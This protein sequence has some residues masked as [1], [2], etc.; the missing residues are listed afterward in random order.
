MSFRLRALAAWPAGEPKAGPGAAA[1]GLSKY[2]APA[3]PGCYGSGARGNMSSVLFIA[4]S[5]VHDLYPGGGRLSI[6]FVPWR[7][8]YHAPS[9]AML[10]VLS[11]I[12]HRHEFLFDCIDVFHDKRL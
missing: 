11:Q 8:K 12:H 6:P 3:G 2:I 9:T 4:E 7:G 1:G 10:T 5:R